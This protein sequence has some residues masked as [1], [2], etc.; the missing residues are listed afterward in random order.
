LNNLVDPFFPVG[1]P[2]V[3]FCL[4]TA[5]HSFL[6]YDLQENKNHICLNVE[7]KPTK[8]RPTEYQGLEDLSSYF[9]R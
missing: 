6:K 2:L 5:L 7:S 1:S 4:S 8:H 9:L 3:E